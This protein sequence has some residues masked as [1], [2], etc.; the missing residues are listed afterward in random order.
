MD[1]QLKR[2]VLDICV[3]SVLL[4]QESYGYKIIK[5]LSNVIEI[6]VSTLYPI[7]NRLEK[8]GAVTVHSRAYN[9]RL[10]K[11]YKITAVGKKR[12]QAFLS[13]WENLTLIYEY[14]KGAVEQYE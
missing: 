14:I 10:R 8:A 9:G 4:K 12:V 2:G 7:L 6:S 13:E 5:D 3:L 11:Y 1:I